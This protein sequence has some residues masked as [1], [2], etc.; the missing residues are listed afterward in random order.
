MNFETDVNLQPLHTFAIAAKAR[1]LVTVS[2]PAECEALLQHPL[3]QS[4][5][6]FILGG[7]SNTLFTGDYPGLIVKMAIPGIALIKETNEHVWLQV[8][9]GV[10][11][12]TLVLYCLEQNYA[13]LENLSL[14]PGTV[15]A[16]PI[17]NIGAY[18]AELKD[19]FEH[20]V[21]LN[22]DTGTWHTLTAAD[23]QFGY[24]DSIFKRELAT[25]TMITQVCL[26]LYKQPQFNLSYPALAHHFKEI[27]SAEL[28]LHTLSEAVMAI[29]REKLPDPATLPN[30]GSF[31][32]N[33]I[34]ASEHWRELQ[35]E[36]PNMPSYET[37]HHEHRK[38][39]A[40]WL[41]EHCGFKGKRIGGTGTHD[42]QALVIINHG[43][44]SGQE[45][46]DFSRLI[47][48]EVKARFGI[49]L[50]P[51]VGIVGAAS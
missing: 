44:A 7:G 17:Q 43:N 3:W 45:I 9:A 24:R 14:I 16:A 35:N 38:I 33:P 23:C 46:L 5:P 31:F 40:G 18:G 8:G 11:W 2:S 48:A 28:S 13:G 15:G 51:E 20:V 49:S 19:V 39:P 36:Y 32:K 27:P 30:A 6:H 37:D 1:H 29:R 47:I 25:K 26:R 22:T 4:L 10:N 50:V 21:M 41:I 12:H 42:H 34:I